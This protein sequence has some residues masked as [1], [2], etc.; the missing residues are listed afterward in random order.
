MSELLIGCGS[1]LRKKVTFEGIASEWT[2]LTTLDCDPEVKPDVVHD[3]NVLPYPF[4]DGQF[5]EIHA[6]EVL[7]HC[8]RQGDWRFF[9]DQFAEFHR[10]LKPGG[11]FIGTVPM[12]DSPWAWGDPGHT[13]VITRGSLVFLNREEYSQLGKTAMT[14]Y[15]PWLKCD[16]VTRAVTETEHMMGF[17][18]Q[19]RK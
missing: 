3:L 11:Y 6:Y 16:F 15:R 8:G 17:V 12:W 7:E 13:R 1:N 5:G 2:K 4:D 18:L 9:F 10:L 19:A 14:D